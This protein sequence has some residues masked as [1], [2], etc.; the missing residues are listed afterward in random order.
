MKKKSTQQE[1]LLFVNTRFC[2]RDWWKKDESEQSKKLSEKEQLEDACWNGLIWVMLPEICETA[3]NRLL[4]LWAVNDANSF[5][6]LLYGEQLE[7]GE[8]EFSVNPYVFM[9]NQLFN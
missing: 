6:D 8:K 3:H 2:S 7:R 9:E 4:T 1:I 5:I